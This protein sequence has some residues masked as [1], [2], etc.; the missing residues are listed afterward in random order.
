M[1][2]LILENMIWT[3]VEEALPDIK[4][5]VV[6]VGSCEQ[7]GP[8]TTFV[9]DT[10]RAYAFSKQLGERLGRQILVCP[11]VGY[12][13]STHHM[14]FP[15]T[16]TL[17]CETFISVLKDIA[18][19]LHAHHIP[20]IVF[21][22]GHGGN[23]GSLNVAITDL[24]YKYDIDAYYTGM[25]FALFEEGITPEMG[26]TKKRGHASE[27]ETS[28]AMALCPEVVRAERK[29]GEVVE[30]FIIRGK[31]APFRYGGCAWDWKQDA[32]RNGA[33]G[34]A[35]LA[36]MEDGIRLNNIALDKVEK[37]LRYII[38]KR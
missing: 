10:A 34:D 15:G 17:S 4:I 14:M 13:V 20:K 21:I 3:E 9:T 35:R 32:S 1:S 26:W 31:D 33:L 6:P 28:Q 5:A 24:K 37:M 7:H 18:I 27:S 8:N 25:G 2:A 16:I 38:E 11:P 36:N 30:D 23:N 29:K 12:G 22:N 19:A